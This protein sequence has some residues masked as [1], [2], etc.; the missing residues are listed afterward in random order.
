M[1][2][3]AVVFLACGRRPFDACWQPAVSLLRKM[4]PG[5]PWPVYLVPNKL[6]TSVDGLD[7]M[8]ETGAP[9]REWGRHVV[10]TCRMIR[11]RRILVLMDDYFAS[12]PWDGAGLVEAVR[13]MDRKAAWYSR[14]VP[15]PAGDVVIDEQWTICSPGT[16]YRCSLQPAFWER[17]YLGRLARDVATPWAFELDQNGE[18]GALHL[19]TTRSYRPLSYVNALISGQHNHEANA[20]CERE[21]VPWPR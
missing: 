6:T 3:V 8:Y 5:C 15:T 20:L 9:L 4:W 13:L 1:S 11:E 14:V 12:A 18:S 21:G 19:S 16:A 2:D 7:G 17:E 10:A